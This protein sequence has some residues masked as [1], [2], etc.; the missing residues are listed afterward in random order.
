MIQY[1]NAKT[2]CVVL[3]DGTP[4]DMVQMFDHNGEETDDADAAISCVAG[5]DPDGQWYSISLLQEITLH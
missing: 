3:C 1:F 5:P 2:R 4:L